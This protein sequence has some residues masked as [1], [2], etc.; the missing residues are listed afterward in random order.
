MSTYIYSTVMD[1]LRGKTDKYRINYF[2]A[3]LKKAV[4]FPC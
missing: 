2:V 1:K 4:F 3:I